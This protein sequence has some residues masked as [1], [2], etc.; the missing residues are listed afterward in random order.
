M[1]RGVQA[2]NFEFMLCG[3]IKIDV[4]CTAMFGEITHVH[5]SYHGAKLDIE[6]YCFD[7]DA[8]AARETKQARRC[9]LGTGSDR[10]RQ[11]T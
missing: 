2:F 11:G 7:D 10:P 5:P 6:E 1:A 8:S 3:V 4:H 9:G